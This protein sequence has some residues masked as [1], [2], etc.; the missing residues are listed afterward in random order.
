[1]TVIIDWSDLV[2]IAL[3]VLSILCW[4]I[5]EAVSIIRR[6]KDDKKEADDD[7]GDCE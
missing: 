5:A 1:M 4:F 7:E 6:N 2:A 3:V